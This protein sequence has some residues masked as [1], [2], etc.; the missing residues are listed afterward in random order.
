GGGVPQPGRRDAECAGGAG[1]WGGEGFPR[2]GPARP[3]ARG[4]VPPP[5]RHP[6]VRSPPLLGRV[7]DDAPPLLVVVTGP[8]ASGK[9]RLAEE[10]AESLGLPLVT[11]DGIKETLFDTLGPGDQAWSSGLV[12]AA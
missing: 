7:T 10:L 12:E 2:T 8:P 3:P 4:G 6:A 9:S 5:R 1:G 11:K